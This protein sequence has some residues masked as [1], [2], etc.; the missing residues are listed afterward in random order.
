MDHFALPGDE[1]AVAAR[2]RRLHRNFMGYTT[3]R[4][5]DM[6]GVGLSAIGDLGGAFAQNVKKLPHY[7]AALDADAFPIDRGYAL[8]PDD[9]IRRHVIT[10]LMCNF[11]VDR[12]DVA[13]RFG[14]DFD[15]YFAAELAALTAP[16]GPADDGF[17][18]ASDAAL[19]VSPAGRLFVRNIC[20]QFDR[21]LAA[22]SAKP[23]FS[24][25]I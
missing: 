3:K 5:G 15:A 25:T 6:L 21:Y 19:E 7:Y 14:I 23:T 18:I 1:L 12:K 2:E 24:R 22:R 8:T 4:A 20:M 11:F 10:E 13:A 9:L 17:L 16:G